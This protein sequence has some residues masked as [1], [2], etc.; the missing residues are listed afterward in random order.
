MGRRISSHSRFRFDLPF[1][2]A[3]RADPDTLDT[4]G[5]VGPLT[6]Q[7]YVETFWRVA[8]IR[9]SGEIDVT[10]TRDIDYPTTGTRESAS[11][12]AEFDAT[13]VRTSIEG[14]FPTFTEVTSDEGNVFLDNLHHG[15]KAA[16]LYGDSMEFTIAEHL[17]DADG[18]FWL[19]PFISV[20]PA[21]DFAT[22]PAVLIEGGHMPKPYESLTEWDYSEVTLSLPLS[23]GTVTFPVLV[24]AFE[25][26]SLQE[27]DDVVITATTATLEVV[28]WFP[29]ADNA[30]LAAWDTTTGLQDNGGPGG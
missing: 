14:E 15:G 19:K 11:V 7:Q 24:S 13:L 18:D 23:S 4:D 29:Y 16:F 12:T 9:I 8:Q 3:S 28:A 20:S 2:E 5:A 30:G 17:I 26:G 10:F 6:R 27:V 1:G 22:E 25:F 21:T